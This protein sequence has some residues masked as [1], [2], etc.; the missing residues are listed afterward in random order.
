M[1]IESEN[2]IQIENGK[3]KEGEEQVEGLN[4]MCPSCLAGK[5]VR[6]VAA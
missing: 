3:G 5:A 6:G 2:T 4:R 1:I